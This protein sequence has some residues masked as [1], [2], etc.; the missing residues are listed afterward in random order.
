[1]TGGTPDGG[2][3][4]LAVNGGTLSLDQVERENILE[5]PSDELPEHE[6]RSFVLETPTQ[7]TRFSSFEV[8]PPAYSLP[9][10]AP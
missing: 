10:V 2:D 7:E 9:P 8:E 5:E 1:M 6:R 4:F 3:I